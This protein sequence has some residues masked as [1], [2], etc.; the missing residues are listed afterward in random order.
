LPPFKTISDTAI[1]P[2]PHTDYLTRILTRRHGS[3]DFSLFNSDSLRK[4][5][6]SAP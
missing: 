5:I 4:A 1:M 6:T 2:L 3:K